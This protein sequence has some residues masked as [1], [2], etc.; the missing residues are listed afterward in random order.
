MVATFAAWQAFG[1][2]A[3]NELAMATVFTPISNHPGIVSMAFSGN[4]YGTE[5]KFQSV[6]APLLNAFPKSANL[7]AT[8]LGWI[9]GLIALA[10]DNGT[11]STSQPDRV[12]S[13]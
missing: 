11:I 10:G 4:Y 1:T 2:T 8:A 7:T 12:R 3:P 9:D 6:I 5:E 13:F